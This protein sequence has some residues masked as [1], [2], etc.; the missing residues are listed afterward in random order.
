[1]TGTVG[2]V[3]A[4]VA[5]V[6]ALVGAADVAIVVALD[7]GV[8]AA[9]EPAVVDPVVTAA[10]DDATVVGATVVPIVVGDPEV[11][12]VAA[13]VELIDEVDPVVGCDVAVEEPVAVVA[14]VGSVVGT[15][16]TSF[17]DKSSFTLPLRKRA[18]PWTLTPEA[19]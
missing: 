15:V 13:L 11:F 19:E 4:A 10:V 9:V 3:E 12:C 8:I 16:E 1:M 7:V 2:G 6:L 5:T 18:V 14:L 17:N